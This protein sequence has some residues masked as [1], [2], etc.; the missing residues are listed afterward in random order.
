MFVGAAHRLKRQG[1]DLRF[2]LHGDGE[3]SGWV[4]DIIEAE[5]LTADILRRTSGTPVTVTLD[6]AHVLVVS[7]HNE[8]LTLTTL[9]AI[10]HGVPV[11]STD[12]GAQSDVIPASALVP[13][14]A[15]LAVRHL[16][17][18]VANLVTDEEAREL[19]WRKERKA[20]KKLLSQQSASS[21][22]KEEVSSW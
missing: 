7:S 18:V 11:V 5:G 10:A 22:F 1:H 2:I 19:L 6:E 8:G 9:E 15:R 12:V 13:R 20:E 3:L 4:D 14:Y 21:W 16:A 17:E